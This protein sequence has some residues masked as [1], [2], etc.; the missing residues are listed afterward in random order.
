MTHFKTV[1]TQCGIIITQ[2]RCPDQNKTIKWD[3]CDDCKKSEI[4][5]DVV[6]E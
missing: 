3:V 5:K 2:C 6:E 1:C 4:K